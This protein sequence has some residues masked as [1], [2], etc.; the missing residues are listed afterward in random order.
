MK[1]FHA[2][3]ISLPT[4]SVLLSGCLAVGWPTPEFGLVSGK[5]MITDETVEGLSREDTTREEVL[6]SIGAPA[7]TIPENDRIFVYEW[8]TNQNFGAAAG[9]VG[10]GGMYGGAGAGGAAAGHGVASHIVLLEF[11]ESHTLA[12]LDHIK[13][14][15]G[16]HLPDEDIEHWASGYSLCSNVFEKSGDE[17]TAYCSH[18]FAKGE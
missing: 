2:I 3:N 7:R 18:R 1:H 13:F 8:Q 14:Y 5:G 15:D 4:V 16:F 6:L 9:F 12:R 17:F 10:G 11:D